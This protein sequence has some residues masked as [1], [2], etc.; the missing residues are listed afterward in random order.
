MS[1]EKL[2]LKFYV[3]G[4]KFRTGWKEQLESMS[5]ESKIKLV[6]E[7]TNRFDKNA[8]KIL[9][10]ADGFLGYVPA[11]TGEALVVAEALAAGMSLT[12]SITELSPDFEPWKALEVTV[13]E[14]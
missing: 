9:T 6:P 2:N 11:K 8:V 14:V 3:A 12:A 5:E 13:E 7:P 4:V 1:E 10:E